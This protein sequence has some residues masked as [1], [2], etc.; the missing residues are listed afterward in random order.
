MILLSTQYFQSHQNT[1]DS[2]V[3]PPL[4][5]F[6]AD[7]TKQE[8][9]VAH[10]G[11]DAIP[12]RASLLIAICLLLLLLLSACAAEPE[13]TPILTPTLLPPT[14]EPTATPS[15]IAQLTTSGT[16]LATG[17]ARGAIRT[18]DEIVIGA[19]YPLSNPQMMTN[20]FAMLAATNLAVFDI[21]ERGGIAG[22]V[23]RTVV[24]DTGS[25]PAQGALFA[26][27]LITI[28]CVAA[29]VGVF[30]SNV[31]LAVKDVAKQ[32]HIPVIFADPYVDKVTTDWTTEVFRLAPTRTMLMTIMSEWLTALGDYNGDGERLAVVIVENTD[33]GHSRLQRLQEALHGSNLRVRGFSVD[34]PATDFSPTIAR[35]VALDQLPD[36]IFLYLHNGEVI[37]FA[38][39]LIDAGLGPERNSLLVTTS[40]IL[41]DQ[42]FWQ[43]VP[44][45]NFLIALQ[46]GPWPSTVTPIG[47]SFAQRFQQYFNRWPEASAFEAY[48]AVWLM[49]N[50]ISRAES[51]APDAIIEAL[52]KTDIS[53]ASGHYQFPY[54]TATPPDGES[55]PLY[56]W[57]QWPTPPVFFLQYTEPEQPS[58]EMR[59][60]WPPAY[61]KSEIPI[62]PE[63][64]EQREALGIHHK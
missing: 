27:R 25:L 21:N 58:A 7:A 33:Y 38:K 12:T 28:D 35:I 15:P 39:Q 37:P 23:L 56:M 9:T 11:L 30:H 20:G 57:H 26:E 13:P 64:A 62:A 46:I 50:A 3:S 32:Y 19:L 24:Y 17:C 16:T 34:L 40:K 59:I 6:K 51:L 4:R 43:T 14:S 36:V 53:L 61:S 52:E 54:G 47:Q 41:D 55:I 31:A 49:A 2:K 44:N 5:R 10:I 1:Y 8:A 45:G 29:I 48:D 18:E 42:L 60:V 63:L 22:K